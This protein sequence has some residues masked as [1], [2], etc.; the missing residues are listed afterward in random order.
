MSE[1]CGVSSHISS[2]FHLVFR[3]IQSVSEGHYVVMM[4]ETFLCKDIKHFQKFMVARCDNEG[5][6]VLA[7]CVAVVRLAPFKL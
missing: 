5:C 3:Q 6:L 4:K 2:L 1:H 7:G